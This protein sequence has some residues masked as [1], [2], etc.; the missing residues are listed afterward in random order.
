[1]RWSQARRSIATAG[2][3][4]SRCRAPT[5]SPRC[6]R[7]S[8]RAPASIRPTLITWKRTARARRSATRSKRRRLARRSAAPARP[9]SR[10][11][12]VRSS[13]TSATWRPPPGMAGLVKAIYCLQ[14][15]AVPRSLHFDAPNPRIPFAELNLEVVREL[16]PLDPGKRLVIGVNSFGFGGANGHVILESAP[17]HAPRAAP[18]PTIAGAAPGFRAQR[19]CAARCRAGNGGLAAAARRSRALR[20]R[21]RRGPVPRLAPPSRSR[22]RARAASRRPIGLPSSRSKARPQAVASGRALEQPGGPVFVYAGNG[23]QWAGMGRRLLDEDPV[24]RAAVERVDAICS[25]PFPAFDPG[26]AA[27]GRPPGEAGSD[28]SG[29]AP[30]LRDPG[31]DHRMPARL[32]HRARRHARAQRRRDRRGLGLR[33]AV[34]RGGDAHRVPPQRL[35]GQDARRRRDDRGADRRG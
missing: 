17:A 6:S 20:H 19:S 18:A 12:S 34:A 1:M 16:Q 25:P 21:P 10:C 28:R 22:V 4:A 30:A 32:G 5:R 15:R 33:R 23:A 11:A 24:F 2:P 27:R 13:P 8:T 9:A 3:T 14:H 7:R 31:R 35:A 26:N 29:A